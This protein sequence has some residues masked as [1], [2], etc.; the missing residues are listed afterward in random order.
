MSVIVV[1]VTAAKSGGAL[2]ILNQF[3]D[4][5]EEYDNHN[6]FIVFVD[7]GFR[8]REIEGVRYV[9]V[10][11]KGWRDRILWDKEGFKDWLK[12][13]HVEPDLIISLQNTGVNYSCE[14]PQLI[15][16]HQLLAIDPHRWNPFKRDEFIL[17]CYKN[18]YPYFVKQ[19]LTK[20]THVV[21]QMSFIKDAFL[22]K[23]D[24]PEG[25][26]HVVPPKM[27]LI[28]FN[29]METGNK[30]DD[31]CM[32]FIYPAAG[33]VYKN[34]IVL[35]RALCL[36]KKENREYYD[37]IRL[38][39]TLKKG[40]CKKVDECIKLWGLEDVVELGGIIPF[41]ELLACYKSMDALLFPSFVETVGLPLLE[42]AGCGM[43]I[44]AADLPYAHEVLQG[45]EGVSYVSYQD[46]RAWAEAVKDV[47]LNRQRYIP[48][49]PVRDTKGWKDFF[50]LVD[51]LKLKR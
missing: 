45:Y 36:L 44:K 16:Y 40:E 30:Y 27:G 33:M 32:H 21:V 46:E 42:A 12:N 13:N 49:K 7:P 20:N 29:K 1:N 14:V 3:L 37:K 10:D 47:C 4:G 2:S 23:F 11:T 31:G 8:Q 35:L 34:H 19:Y 26:V 48:M 28:D 6:Y 38:H 41:Q 15:Y 5:I 22:K 51:M 9:P 18:F 50:E 43:A 39:L 25:H 24:I 17:F